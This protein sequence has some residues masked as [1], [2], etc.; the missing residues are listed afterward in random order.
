MITLRPSDARGHAHHGW[1]ESRHTFSFAGYHDPQHMGFRDLRVINEDCV[2]PGG[3]F[4]THGHR[5]MEI[6]SYVVSGALEHRDSMGN[7]SVIRPGEL[8]RMTA[9]SGVT[10]SEYNPS[11]EEPVRFLQIWLIP[12]ARGL[13]P[14]YE[15]KYF[16]EERQN[17]LRL[18]ASQDGRD[19]S[20]RVYQNASLY[21]AVMDDGQALFHTLPQGR[22]AWLQM[23]RGRVALN[24]T[25]MAQGDGAAVSDIQEL[26]LRALEPS[27][28]LLFELT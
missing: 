27:E 1:L 19:G 24:G 12:E 9:G 3:G 10:H 8:Q 13:T 2:Q 25:E 18:I 22:H 6:L 7:G 16:G 5:D 28:L 17:R 11:N 4:P 23:I 14:S 26:G 15:Q 21:A 20:V